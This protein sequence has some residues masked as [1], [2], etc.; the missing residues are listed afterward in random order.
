MDISMEGSGGLFHFE[1]RGQW[2]WLCSMVLSRSCTP[3][4]GVYHF[5][6]GSTISL[7]NRLAFSRKKQNK[8]KQEKDINNSPLKREKVEPQIITVSLVTPTPNY[9][10]SLPMGSKSSRIFS[11][12]TA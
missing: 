7:L 5:L 3:G 8:S 11:P 2:S 10:A 6:K 1:F 4:F 9:D 12:C